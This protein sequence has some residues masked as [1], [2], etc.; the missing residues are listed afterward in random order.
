M[1]GVRPASAAARVRL[2]VLVR[3][4]GTVGEVTVAVSS[5]R[6]DLDAAAMEA[7][8]SWRFQPARRDGV[9]ITSAALIWVAFVTTP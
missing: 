2:R 3:E 6:P 9:A 8:R 1:A 4:N 5:G 7:A